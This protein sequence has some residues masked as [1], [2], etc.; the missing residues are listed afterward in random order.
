MK[1]KC[2]KVLLCSLIIKLICVSNFAQGDVVVD[3][4]AVI[5]GEKIAK[6][7]QLTAFVT[8][9][10]NAEAQR[11]VD[12]SFI[13]GVSWQMPGY[14]VFIN[15]NGVAGH[16]YVAKKRQFVKGKDV[17]QNDNK[18]RGGHVLNYTSNMH[19]ERQLA[20]VALEEALVNNL[21]VVEAT[22]A[23][24]A[25]GL[26]PLVN[27]AKIPLTNENIP[28]PNEEGTYS[29]EGAL[30]IYTGDNPCQNHCY[31]NGNFSCIEYYNA[32]ATL[33]PKV[34]FHIYFRASEMRLNL[35]FIQ[36][37]DSAKIALLNRLDNLITTNETIAQ[38]F[39]IR[40][41]MQLLD[42]NNKWK[43][44]DGSD[45]CLEDASQWT[46]IKE[47]G[48]MANKINNLLVSDPGGNS[49]TTDERETLFNAIHNHTH[50][51]NIYYHAI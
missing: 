39:R 18:Q 43:I 29:L 11:A 28:Q 33:F 16:V 5:N 42:N 30:H 17:A 37:N 15:N 47:K 36:D 3:Q 23:E 41:S 25:S 2:I 51:K 19:T 9:I 32:L 45:K 50:I 7:A 27:N 48:N 13:A 8:Y 1:K 46:M 10:N 38:N 4:T 31:D 21:P 24:I 22:G 14:A 40:Y 34:D 26:G 20:I 49:L 12:G 44:I 35:K 6:N